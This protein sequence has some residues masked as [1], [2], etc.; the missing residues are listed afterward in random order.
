MK[1]TKKTLK[2]MA[3]A[4]IMG[5]AAFVH[6]GDIISIDV[7]DDYPYSMSNGGKKY[8]NSDMPHSIGETVSIRIRLVNNDLGLRDQAYP[9]EFMSL[10]SS[11]SSWLMAPMLGLSVGGVPRYATM[12]SCLPT[13]VTTKG[14]EICFTDLVFEYIVRPGDLA[15]PLKL[16]NRDMREAV[17]GDEYLVVMPSANSHFY[18]VVDAS[19]ASDV[20]RDAVFSFCDEM[21]RTQV[22][23]H[24]PPADA[25]ADERG[26]PTEDYTLAGA[27]VYIK[28][29]DFDSD[30]VDIAADPY[31]WRTIAQGSS[32]SKKNGNPSIVVDAAADFEGSGSATMYVWSENDD[33]ITPVGAKSVDGSTRKA[34]PI[35][36]STGDTRK[37]F[38][39]KATGTEGQG[40]WIY[41][42]S[43]P[44]NMYGTAGELI[45]NTVSRY[46]MIGEPEKPSVSVTFRGNSWTE[47]TAQS[48][49]ME[50]DYPVE[51]AITLSETFDEDV[52]VTLTPVL[53]N[54]PSGS[55]TNID[56]YANHVIATAPALGL[57][58]GWQLATNSVTF[59]RNEDV[60]KFLYVYPLGATTGSTRNGGTGIEFQITVE[61]ATAAAY[62][63]TK[64]PGVLYVNAAEPNVVDP[65]A[66]QAYA[67]TAGKARDIAISVDDSCRNM[68][69]LDGSDEVVYAG[70]NYYSVVW[71]RN[72]DT[73][74]STM[75]WKGLV[76]DSDG[77]LT[78]EGVRYPNSGTYLASQITITGPEGKKVVIPVSAEVSLPRTVTATPDRAD[79]TYA[80]GDTVKLTI[81]LSKRDGEDMYA[82]VEPLNEAATNCIS[83]AQVIGAN[84]KAT[85]VGVLVPG[86]G[87]AGSKTIDVPLLDGYC[88][89]KFQ[90][91]L[92]SEE[93]YD[94]SKVVDRYTPVPVTIVCEN[95][96]PCGKPG[97]SMNIGGYS[98]TNNAVLPS[99]V[100]AD[101]TISLRFDAF[102]VAADRR[103]L[104][105]PNESLIEWVNGNDP[106][107][108]TNGLFIVKWAFYNPGGMLVDTRITVG[109]SRTGRV[110]TNFVFTAVGDWQVSVQMLDKDM[111]KALLADGVTREEIVSWEGGVPYG[112]QNGW[113]ET[114]LPEDEWGPEYRVTVPV[115]EKANV[116]VELLNATVGADENL[117]F[118]EGQASASFNVKLSVP[119]EMPLTVR[120]WLERTARTEGVAA[121]DLGTLGS[122]VLKDVELGKSTN[123]YVDV[124]FGRGV[125]TVNV[126]VTYMDGTRY[127]RYALHAKVVTETQNT[128]GVKF[129]DY[130]I[131]G[132]TD[133]WVF[134]VNPKLD[135]IL[136]NVGI[137]FNSSTGL[138]STNAVTLTQNQEVSIDWNV[139]DAI[140]MD[141]TNNFTVT[142]NSSEPG[143]M[144][145]TNNAVRGTYKTKFSTAGEKTVTLT[146]ND[147]DGGA[148]FYEWHFTV[149]ASKRLYV[150]PHGPN[151]DALSDQ[152][153][154]TYMVA[155]GL[156]VGTVE[157]DGA[158]GDIVK[159]MQTWDYSVQA[160]TAHVYARGLSA[161]EIDTNTIV[162][163]ERRGYPT[164]TGTLAASAGDAYVNSWSTTYDSFVYAFVQN[165]AG[166]G[167][168][169]TPSLK[170]KPQAGKDTAMQED[171]VMPLAEK[172][173]IAYPDR[174]VEVIFSREWLEADNCGDINAD[175]VPDLF[176]IKVWRGGR[177]LSTAGDAAAGGSIAIGSDLLDLADGNPDEDFIPGVWQAQGKLNLVNKKL[178]SYAPIGYPLNN[179]LE[180]RGFH[181]GLNETSLAASDPSFSEAE[182]K[183]WEAFVAA[184]PD[185]GLDPATPDLT[186][187]SPEPH[188]GEHPRMDPTLADTDVDGMPD[189]WEYFF[190][191]QARVW[192]PAARNGAKGADLGKKRDGQLFVFERFNPNDI[193]RG[194]V[195]TDKEV[196]ERF[197]PCVELDMTVE[198]F[199]PDFDGDGLTDLEELVIGTNP[200]H[201][202]TD[203]DH[204]CDGWEVMHSLDPLN[205]SK[206]GNG[207]GDFMAYLSLRRYMAAEIPNADPNAPTTYVF[208]L[209]NELREY[210]DYET[211]DIEMYA[212]ARYYDDEKKGPY[213]Q[214]VNPKD[215]NGS[216]NLPLY[217]YFDDDNNRRYTVDAND[218]DAGTNTIM[219]YTSQGAITIRDVPLTAALIAPEKLDANGRP[220]LYG[221]ETDA[222][223]I[224]IPAVWHWSYPMLDHKY[225]D[226]DDNL[227]FRR[228]E[229]TIPEGTL[230]GS[231]THILIHDQVEAA[232]GFDPRT[233]WYKDSNG[234]VADRWNP[235]INSALAP[236]D[237]TGEAINT[238]PYTD[239][240]EYLVMRYRHDF[241]IRYYN[242]GKYDPKDIWSTFLAFSTKPNIV[243]AKTDIEAILNPTNTTE[244]ATTNDTG[245]A[246]TYDTET[247]ANLTSTA[248]ISEYL[249]NAFAEAGS[250]RSPVKGHGADTE[251]RQG[252]WRRHRRRRR[253]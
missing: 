97:R 200:C 184:N 161:G 244:S 113:W 148:N 62:F 129:S 208:D 112:D 227:V 64:T 179:R 201:W 48:G 214:T 175:G 226:A 19:N 99:S 105:Q 16:L 82:F 59:T 203:A 20:Q 7:L 216:D 192:A 42:S 91:V 166:D 58:N 8:P 246:T 182:Q 207:D 186:K 4:C 119:A 152:V 63:V 197:D 136:A 172:D 84:G 199:N 83:G 164:Q 223:P 238:D 80:E 206:V 215:A 173:A 18:N 111:I 147:K 243:Y 43:A 66:N 23:G 50:A 169:F 108:F 13:R 183:A 204:M 10:S 103:L 122:F 157:A 193:V 234:Y 60:E 168:V 245:S 90:V 228:G 95:A 237:S 1:M 24:Y 249:A 224:P 110:S 14:S 120:L 70:T 127:S 159:F 79:L 116:S 56:V 54:G 167:T 187:W 138:A 198:N 160:N 232:F 235:Q 240:D 71:E 132:A 222:P 21:T 236:T 196:L 26:T 212:M 78:L 202:D 31:V 144:S 92:C 28:T 49:Y 32:K 155:D 2:V 29:I 180:I 142:W 93:T 191:Y 210:R 27:G 30:Y 77:N 247:A 45:K 5:A 36:I 74:T 145:T 137:S 41:M 253:A 106:A 251:P 230:L 6:G 143:S 107:E 181:H 67:F 22:I 174:Y 96:A 150:Y 126:P 241:G 86:T 109:S 221:L 231:T 156:G 25:A 101:N 115:D 242:D 11:G 40:A 134:N 220:Y 217:Y 94:K 98:V 61:P 104:P 35:T 188:S 177:L 85:G 133:Y 52:T 3:M 15:Q 46:V 17:E 38:V 73:S 229:Y 131:E 53:K 225:R 205:G 125:D 209:G 37:S 248:N 139:S 218:P 219:R 39:L 55:E 57:G 47:A 123:E 69:Y 128:Q 171:V 130:Y 76:P 178:A 124:A 163:A 239:Y 185:L 153:A 158:L 190:W 146:I 252:S 189:G 151:G 233:G 65:V 75:E 176:A 100:P 213:I 33:I 89:P 114:A 51:M 121:G 195:I 140:R 102:D 250:T 81:G 44:T 118:N 194:T 9:W 149:E 211:R 72:D 154:S 135:S 141:E 88:E 117:G 34:L 165:T 87:T 68:R 12:V 170:I 162:L